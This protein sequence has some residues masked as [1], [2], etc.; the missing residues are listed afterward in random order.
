MKLRR[1]LLIIRNNGAIRMKAFLDANVFDW[2][3]EPANG[4]MVRR[5]IAAGTLRATTGPEVAFEIRR[6]P[7]VNKRAVLE[8]VLA[9]TFH[10]SQ[11]GC[12]GLDWLGAG[13]LSVLARRS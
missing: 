8:H 4:A 12:R 3:A 11:L 13:W 5:A 1:T 2:L 6:T 7:D 10:W 9:L